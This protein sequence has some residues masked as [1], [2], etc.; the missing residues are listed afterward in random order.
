MVG[1]PSYLVLVPV[2]VL[3]TKDLGVVL[4]VCLAFCTPNRD[5]VDGGEGSGVQP[6]ALLGMEALV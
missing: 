4:V 6:C 2:V 5:G 1:G 3:N